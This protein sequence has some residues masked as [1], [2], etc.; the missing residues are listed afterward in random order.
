MLPQKLVFCMF[1]NFTPHETTLPSQSLSST[2]SSQPQK[3]RN[4]GV[5]VISVF[6]VQAEGTRHLSHLHRRTS[7][8][9]GGSYSSLD[10]SQ[11]LFWVLLTKN[12]ECRH[13]QLCHSLPK[14]LRLR[15]KVQ[16]SS[17]ERCHAEPGIAF[18]RNL[19]LA[20]DEVVGEHGFVDQHVRLV[21]SLH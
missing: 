2:P 19:S 18:L 10:G 15:V 14:L 3:L 21:A 4:R 20:V 17:N 9:L 13:T 6:F 11:R 12:H 1:Q 16:A 7:F 8:R 5:H